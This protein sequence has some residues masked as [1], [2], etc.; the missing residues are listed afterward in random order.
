MSIRNACLGKYAGV[1]DAE[2]M[3]WMSRLHGVLLL[4]RGLKSASESS[5]ER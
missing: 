5:E 1:L 2:L 3:R 4:Q